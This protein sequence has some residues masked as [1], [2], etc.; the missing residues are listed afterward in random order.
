MF[1]FC[2][3]V[4]FNDSK[5]NLLYILVFL[6]PETTLAKKNTQKPPGDFFTKPPGVLVLVAARLQERG[7]FW[8]GGVNLSKLGGSDS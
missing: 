3:V 2:R 7:E 8:L 1:F 5:Y 6:T 4:F